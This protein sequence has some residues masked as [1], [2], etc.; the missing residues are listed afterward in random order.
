MSTFTEYPSTMTP[1]D[2]AV[3][4]RENR[5]RRPK[6]FRA[7]RKD[8][9]RF[10]A[11]GHE[12]F[13]FTSAAGE[14]AN[15]MRLIVENHDFLG[16]A[17]YRLRTALHGWPIIPALLHRVAIIG[18]D[19]RI[20][21]HVIIDEGLHIPHGNVVID[22]ITTIGRGCIVCPWV[23]IGVKQGQLVG[24]QIGDNVFIG[25]GAKLLG[26]FI[27]GDGASIGAGAV[28]LGDVAAGASVAGVPARVI[29]D[30]S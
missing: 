5:K 18:F 9:L 27:I 16:V 19:I 30:A 24:P 3:L 28:V 29:G 23:S 21:E 2:F 11:L 1:A 25:T 17:L 20:G 26:N 14:R 12:R 22:G 6:F 15:A 8:G 4:I 13:E 10:S 7:I